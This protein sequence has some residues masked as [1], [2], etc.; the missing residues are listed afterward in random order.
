MHRPGY[1]LYRE[2][3]VTHATQTKGNTMVMD[4]L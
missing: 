2:K 4:K 1:T 3:T